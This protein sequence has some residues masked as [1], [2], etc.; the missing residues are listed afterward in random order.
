MTSSKLE[1][2]PVDSK[3]TSKRAWWNE[4]KFVRVWVGDMLFLSR[5]HVLAEGTGAAH[6]ASVK[7]GAMTQQR[8]FPDII[9]K[10]RK[11]VEQHLRTQGT[12]R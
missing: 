12:R 9:V 4:E 10:R 5:L 7:A 11:A 8:N 1:R 3:M 2:A 6:K